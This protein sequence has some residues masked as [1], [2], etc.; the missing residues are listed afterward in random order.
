MV[1]ASELSSGVC[2]HLFVLELVL[3]LL[4]SHP[5]ICNTT[6][7]K[8]RYIHHPIAGAGDTVCCYNAAG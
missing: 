5:V 1:N 4:P 7:C 3:L 8:L 2:C 6:F